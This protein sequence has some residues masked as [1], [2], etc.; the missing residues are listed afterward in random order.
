M[1][2]GGGWSGMK[3]S[4]WEG[5]LNVMLNTL[6]NIIQMTAKFSFMSSGLLGISSK[7]PHF[8]LHGDQGWDAAVNIQFSVAL[9]L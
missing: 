7:N 5:N 8:L 1:E 2:V 6:K 3:T 4:S 9:K